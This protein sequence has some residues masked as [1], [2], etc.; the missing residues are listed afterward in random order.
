MNDKAIKKSLVAIKS[1]IPDAGGAVIELVEA[2][3]KV[4]GWPEKITDDP[5]VGCTDNRG[6]RS[7]CKK[8]HLCMKIVRYIAREPRNKLIDGCKLASLKEKR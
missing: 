2:Y 7:V 1:V 8:R 4:E 3:L 6:I 5:C